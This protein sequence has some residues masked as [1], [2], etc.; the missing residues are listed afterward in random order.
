MKKEKSIPMRV[1][2]GFLV[3]VALWLLVYLMWNILRLLQAIAAMYGDV[4]AA[5][6]FL[7]ISTLLAFLIISVLGGKD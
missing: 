1:L 2:I 5:V 4:V 7:M 6:S 3:W